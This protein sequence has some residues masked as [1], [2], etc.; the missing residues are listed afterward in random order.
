M[1]VLMVNMVKPFEGVHIHT[2]GSKFNTSVKYEYYS[3]SVAEHI[4][5]QLQVAKIFSKNKANSPFL[6]IPLS[7][8]LFSLHFLFHLEDTDSKAYHL[9]YLARLTLRLGKC[10][11]E[12]DSA[13]L[14][15]HTISPIRAR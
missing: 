6:Q 8:H 9:Q 15:G 12:Q 4:F 7:S 3:I 5:D 13:C 10:E 2:D 14:P 1:C 11:F